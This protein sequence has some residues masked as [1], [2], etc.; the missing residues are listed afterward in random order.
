V[1]HGKAGGIVD[2]DGYKTPEEKAYFTALAE[3]LWDKYFLAAGAGFSGGYI[4]YL[5]VNWEGYHELYM[6]KMEVYS[7]RGFDKPRHN[8]RLAVE[9]RKMALQ[10]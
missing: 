5:E 8:R 9:I 7:K 3:V 4:L 1:A 6:P 2:A 10:R